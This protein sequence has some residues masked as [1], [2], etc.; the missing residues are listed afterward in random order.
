MG[1]RIVKKNAALFA[2][3]FMGSFLLAQN[4]TKISK[5]LVE[6][7]N[8]STS[9]VEY[10]SSFSNDAKEL[11]F[12]RSRQEWGKGNLKSA[13]YHS[14]FDGENWTKPKI[15]SFS[16]QY[17]DSD[18]HLTKNGNI[19]Y[20][21]SDRPS[22]NSIQSSDIWVVKK[23]D[24][25]VWGT[26]VRL[27]HPIN[28]KN[29]EYSP[30]T[31]GKGNLYFASDRD[32]G[33]GQGDLYVAM[34]DGQGRLKAPTNMGNIINSSTGEWNL[35]ISSD[36]NILI[37]EA[38]Q[39][40]QNVSPYGDLYIS[41]KQ[42]DTWTIPQNIKELNTSGSDLYPFLTDDLKLLY[43]TSSDSLKSTDTNIYVT[44]FA[45]I[46]KK[47]QTNTPVTP[48][49][50]K[51]LTNNSFED[52]YASY[53]PN[54]QNILFESNRDGNWEIYLMDKNG[55]NVQRLTKSTSDNRRPSWH[56]NGKKIIFESNRNG[57]FELFILK[58]KNRKV[59]KL[60][61]PIGN[62][63]PIFASFA[64]NG[65]S[66]AVSFKASESKSNLVLLNKKGRL[67]Q[68]LT[69]NEKRTF[70]P[71][72]SGDGNEIVFFS[73][74]DTNNQDDEIYKLNL[75]TGKETRLT[76]WHKHNFCP[77]WS[78][79]SKKIAYVTSMEGTRPEIYIMDAD[80][81]NQIR[82]TYNKDGETLPNWHP[83]ENKILVTAYRNGNYEI[84]EL[85][86]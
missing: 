61:D 42:E 8:I 20:F 54:G 69:S 64:P 39:K 40:K 17:D 3:L 74:Q 6:E 30:R 5:T 9:L 50:E 76:N 66:I 65:K 71:K 33:Y 15:T 13:I 70:Y 46:L 29:R 22:K 58:I 11:Y 14:I 62:E 55:E 78:H 68:K 10:S 84:C 43:F 31:D 49:N 63:E 52:R 79:N 19:L 28:S 44:D 56:P 83:T 57:K 41:F 23:G 21:I 34:N 45:S 12:A 1:N 2:L 82:L 72:W 59:T 48:I 81:S 32:G 36:G 85:E 80:G 35:G 25:G 24:S 51:C 37:F 75:K 4:S 16:G 7:E 67:L 77:S 26:P 18:P 38:S 27:P 47:Y 86:L 53:S 73:R 60:L